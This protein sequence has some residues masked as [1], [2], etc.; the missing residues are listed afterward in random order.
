[1]PEVVSRFFA[2]LN[3][4]YSADSNKKIIAITGLIIATLCWGG[5]NV[6]GRMSVG[7]IPPIAMSFWR[8]TFS[9]GILLLVCGGRV[10]KERRT[11]WSF[12]WRLL[13]L[14]L[15]SITVYNTFLYLAAQST[16]AVNLALIQT[17]LPVISM[18]LSIPLLRIF[19]PKTQIIG[20]LL[21]VP[22]LLLIF[23]QGDME[24]LRSLSF[25]KG[26]LLMLFATFCW[27]IYTLLLKR[28][29]LPVEGVTLLTVQVFM[30][31]IMLTPFYLWEFTVQGGFDVNPDTLGLITYVV[32]FPSLVAYLAWNHGV[33]VLG[34]NQAAVF[35][36]LIPVFAAMLAI[37]MLG[38][39][40]EGHH[41]LA[42]ICIFGGLW[43]TTRTS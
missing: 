14:S 2:R 23:S 11:I 5:N 41:I 39:P 25:G 17:A 40:L 33:K 19:P 18:L 8:W 12:K 30:G 10:W 36:F 9:L 38:E 24:N 15:L 20:G 16:Q 42:A 31:V 26:D 21:A 29:Y 22:G 28:F 6:A 34:A 35:T 1:M 3:N 13:F 37:P 4:K 32:L 43:L 27:A 7:D